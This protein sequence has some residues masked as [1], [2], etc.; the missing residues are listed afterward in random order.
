MYDFNYHRPKTLNDALA[1][2]K[3]KA[4]ARP[5]SGGM[6][7][8]PTLKQ[9]LAKPSDVVDLGGIKELAGIKAEGGGLTIGAMTRHAD[10]A[11]SAEVKSTIPALAHLA[12]HIGDPAVRNR[13][14]MGGSVANNDPAADYPA[15]VVAL[16]ATVTTTA[17]KHTADAFFKGLFETALKDGELITSI[18]FPKPEKAAYMKFPN[19]ASRYAMVGVFVAKTAAGVRVAVTGAGPCVFRVKAMEDALSK[20]FSSA[21]IKD[22]KIPA[23]GLNSDIHASAEYRAHL[24][25]VMARRAVD[26]AK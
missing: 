4:E 14:T 19:P 6:T 3:G 2:L 17:G 22:I 10:V 5:M 16:N 25:G 13:G 20:N 24:V 18:S 8:I 11:S 1:T 26:A 12:G 9:R 15:A 21:A 23:A 7:L